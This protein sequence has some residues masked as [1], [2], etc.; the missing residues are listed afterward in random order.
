MIALLDWNCCVHGAMQL[1]LLHVAIADLQLHLNGLN[2]PAEMDNKGI[3]LIQLINHN[4]HSNV[5][6]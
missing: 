1:Q 2:V 5:I 6:T 3:K 4:L